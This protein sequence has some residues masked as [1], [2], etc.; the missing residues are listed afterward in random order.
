M[1][2]RTKRTQSETERPVFDSPWC[3]LLRV[4]NYINQCE[5]FV[6]PTAFLF[7]SIILVI[8]TLLPMWRSEAWWVRSLDFPRLQLLVISI[9]LLL[10]EMIL[11]DLSHLKT[12][13]LLAVALFCLIYHAWWIAPYTQ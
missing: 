4:L 8:F 3:A 13:G 10:T 1:G 5:I 2:T 7:A 6:I 9:L 12:W 11:L